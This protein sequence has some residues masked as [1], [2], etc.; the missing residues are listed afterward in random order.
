MN[1]RACTNCNGS[2][3]E[4]E[5]YC[6]R[7]CSTVFKPQETIC[8]SPNHSAC[9]QMVR[10]SMSSSN[11]SRPIS[12]DV[13]SI[14]VDYAVV[15]ISKIIKVGSCVCYLMKDDTFIMVHYGSSEM[16]ST[17][18][19]DVRCCFVSSY[20][21]WD[22]VSLVHKTYQSY[23]RVYF[24]FSSEN[25][26][27]C[28]VPWKVSAWYNIN[29]FKMFLKP[30][31]FQQNSQS[32][33]SF[34]NFASIT[35]GTGEIS[36]VCLRNNLDDQPIK[37]C[38]KVTIEYVFPLA[39]CSVVYATAYFHNA[40]K[41][42]SNTSEC[43]KK[44]IVFIQTVNGTA[45]RRTVNAIS[46]LLQNVEKIFTTDDKH[47]SSNCCGMIAVCKEF[48]SPN[49][50]NELPQNDFEWNIHKLAFRFTDHNFCWWEEDK[51]F[52][53]VHDGTPWNR[54]NCWK[55]EDAFFLPQ[56]TEKV[57][58]VISREHD[59]QGCS[60]EKR[61]YIVTND[62][63]PRTWVS[64]DPTSE[65][66]YC[67]CVEESVYWITV[68]KIVC[69]NHKFAAVVGLESH[70]IQW[71][72]GDTFGIMA[73][74]QLSEG[75]NQIQLQKKDLD[76]GWKP[77]EREIKGPIRLTNVIGITANQD[78]FAAWYGENRKLIC[79][80][81]FNTGGDRLPPH[82]RT[83]EMSES[84]RTNWHDCDGKQENDVCLNETR[85]AVHCQSTKNC[86]CKIICKKNSRG[87]PVHHANNLTEVWSVW[88][89]D[90]IFHVVY[91]PQKKVKMCGYPWY[92]ILSAFY[93][94]IPENLE[95][96]VS[97]CN[98]DEAFTAISFDPVLKVSYLT[99]WGGFS[100]YSSV[101][102][103][104]MFKEHGGMFTDLEKNEEM[105]NSQKTIDGSPMSCDDPI[106]SV[107]TG[108][109]TFTAVRSS[110]EIQT[111]G[112]CNTKCNASLL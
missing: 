103:S 13:I 62:A 60:G 73:F 71:G 8:L 109:S 10:L 64:A 38:K 68:P 53:F 78:S 28:E 101:C 90:G 42:D 33:C 65:P 44:K 31:E 27:S 56:N 85:H 5:N 2:V 18:L 83:P 22:T 41:C 94:S 74:H 96:V 67:S 104:L 91:G 70:I 6:S 89:K 17:K 47:T 75:F 72:G 79:W 15:G 76:S 55:I 106:V 48:H 36:T 82:Q 45:T 84:K 1:L 98:N 110:G 58:L 95:N 21:E 87:V 81:A 112:A 86:D 26:S 39:F 23:K 24:D 108:S 99:T 34:Q 20:R 46:G 14:I 57:S 100:G 54:N 92:Q 107:L 66:I 69:T 19:Q 4:F 32:T 30:T 3:V 9:H 11:P 93:R 102:P 35:D 63:W 50:S 12:D 37:V 111:W 105:S 80:G 52:F 77:I 29:H 49:E 61:Y 51:N 25:S 59:D 97:I 88:P 7:L 40:I 16:T 43:I